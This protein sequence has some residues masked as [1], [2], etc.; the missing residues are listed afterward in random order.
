MGVEEMIRVRKAGGKGK[1]AK[2]IHS[3][4]DA[5]WEMGGK[6]APPTVDVDQELANEAEKTL[7]G[8][9]EEQENGDE[10]QQGEREL[11]NRE[12]REERHVVE[13]GPGETADADNE[14]RDASVGLSPNGQYP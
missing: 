1:A 9:T 6:G 2:V 8:V 11:A 3:W 5:L 13:P 10:A 7:A 12:T 4:K 14:E